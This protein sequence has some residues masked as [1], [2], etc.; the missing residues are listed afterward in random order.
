MTRTND[1]GLIASSAQSAA[2]LLT[3]AWRDYSRNSISNDISDPHNLYIG[4][5]WS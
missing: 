2:R 1:R 5:F 3:F 4:P